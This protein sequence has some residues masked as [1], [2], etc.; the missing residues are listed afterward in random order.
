MQGNSFFR[1]VTL[2]IPGV[3][4]GNLGAQFTFTDQAQIRYARTLHLEAYF[5][6]D[7]AYSYPEQLPVIGDA[8][9]PKMTLTLETNDP[10][11]MKV[12]NSLTKS[13]EIAPGR[14]S[15]TRQSQQWLP[16]T[17]IHRVQSFLGTP[18]PFVRQLLSYKDLYITWQKSYVSFAP[19]GPA[20]V[21]DIAVVLGVWYT[22]LTVDGKKIQET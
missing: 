21:T 18:A 3:V 11:D 17:A 9:A 14:F 20:N 2:K 16:F 1:L 13:K 12:G 15:S 4:G 5:A 22:F 19:G 10:D 8:F 7:L 6:N